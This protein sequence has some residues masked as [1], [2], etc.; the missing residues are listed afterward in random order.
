MEWLYLKIAL[1]GMGNPSA[2]YVMI[3]EVQ[4]YSAAQ[5]AVLARYFRRANFL[6]LGDENQAIMP[7]TAS[8]TQIKQVF[9]E[10]RGKVSECHL[11]TSYRSTPAITDL[12]AKLAVTADGMQISSVQREDTLPQVIEC[13]DEE[14]YARELRRVAEEL[15]GFEGTAAL[16]AL[17]DDAVQKTASLLGEAAPQIIDGSAT[18]PDSGAI[19]LALPLAKGLEFDHVVVV[20]ASAEAFPENDLSRRRLYTA[21]S[22]AT[23]TV[24]V[25]SNGP[26]SSL[27]R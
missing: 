21:I 2:K 16:V 13:A 11:M 25:L 3:D 27:L 15:A 22:R 8:F 20:D 26:L 18:L 6:L 19:L 23:S 12:F 14:H 5:L 7:Q 1:T 10:L 17:D 9:Q 4:D 24:T